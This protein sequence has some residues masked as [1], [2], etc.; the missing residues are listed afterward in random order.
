MLSLGALDP[1]SFPDTIHCPLTLLELNPE[2]RARSKPSVPPGVTQCPLSLIP[3]K[4][5]KSNLSD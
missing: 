1:G 2:D 4:T 5:N 3:A